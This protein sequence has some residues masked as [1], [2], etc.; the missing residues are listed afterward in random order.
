L[1]VLL[2]LI[3]SAPVESR[4]QDSTGGTISGHIHG[5]GDV[6]V[7]GATVMLVNPQTGERKGTWS[8]A[9]GNYLI[10]NVPPGT[11]KLVVSLVGFRDDVRQ[12]V[13]VTAG[14]ILKVN[15]A[16]E[17]AYGSRPEEAAVANPQAAGNR[18]FNPESLPPQIR[19]RLQSMASAAGG[20]T[21]E[22]V[23]ANV[24]FT[25]TDGAT[26]QLA[27]PGAAQG[28]EALS[29]SPD[30][31]ASAANSFLLSGSVAEAA[32]PGER[33]EMRRRFERFRQMRQ[34]ETAPGFGGEGPGGGR[35][36]GGGG[37][38]P[39][40]M[41]MGGRFGGRRPQVNRIRGSVF[42]S[43]TNSALDAHP[44]PLNVANSP[45]IPSYSERAGVNFGGPLSIPGIYHGKD[46]TSFFFNY[47]LTRSRN[48]FDSLATVPSPANRQGN[49]S[50]L[51]KSGFDASGVCLDRDASGNVIDQLYNPQSD[52][53]GP[54]T[55]FAGNS[56]ASVPLDAAATGLL[57]YIPLPNLPGTVQNFHLQEALPNS[58]DR[59]MGRVGHEISSRDNVGVFYFLNS[60]RSTAVSS[61]PLL[62]H[63][64]STLGQN[65]NVNESHTFNPHLINNLI[66][67]FNRQ[68]TST[69]NP[70]A[71]Q[72][73]IS[74]NLGI[75]GISQDPRDWGLPQVSFT[76]FTGL[77]DT[78]P[79]LVRNQTWRA[80]DM[81]IWSAGKHNLRLG[82]EVRRVQMNN[83]Q[84]PDARGTFTFNGFTTSDLTAA[85]Q[86]VGGTGFDFADFLLG[87]PQV[88]TVR[89]GTSSNYFRS[90]VFSGFIQDDWRA[91]THLTLNLGARYE[92]FQPMT[93]KYGHLSDLAVSPGFA[94]A[95][96]LTAQSP[97][98]LPDS[99]IRPD[100][101]NWAPR[102]GIAYR[103]WIAHRLVMRA[104]YGI[105]YDDSIYQRL[106][107]NLANQPP[108]AEASTLT[109]SPQQVL[110]L[111]NGFPQ[112]NPAIARNTYA[113]DPN[114]RTPY[115]QTWNFSVEDEI[116]TDW[117]LTLG[118]VGTKGTKLDLL[119]G[120][121]LATS[122][123]PLDTQSQ[124]SLKNAQQFTY[125][126]SGAS[127]IYQ[128]LTVELRRQFHRG[129][130]LDALYT[131]SKSLDDAS[132][133]G[134]AG[135]TV[136]Q[137]WQ[138]LAAERGLS[139]FDIRHRLTLRHSFE[140]PF[141]DRKRFLNHGG[142][143]AAVLGD[144]RIMGNATIQ[145]G[146]PFT[147]SALGNLSAGAGM[148]AY[149]SLRADA[150]GQPVGLP[151]SQRTTLEFF[152]TAAFAPPVPGAFGNAG[153][154]TIP[155]PGKVNY[156]LSVGRLLTI[157]R[158]KNIWADI[159]L[160]ANNVFNTP[161]YTG[162]ATVVNATDFGRVT[163]VAA[164]RTLTLTLRLRF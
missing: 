63:S 7:P 66:V 32:M 36:F 77:N 131:F 151:T 84:D 125:E 99:L 64:T 42:E 139:S 85:G 95:E 90:W 18:S 113:V 78:I 119:L 141:G 101:N 47:S 48:P 30:L 144:W 53:F 126:T 35:G 46:K 49:F 107:G 122:G 117:I 71:Y 147:A 128:G 34:S 29:E 16:L 98:A 60:S 11:Y 97:G 109:S 112:V 33:E 102:V 62:T 130:S 127:S 10:S 58:T 154:N 82:G 28:G 45:Q 96:V 13:P 80:M 111:Q 69:L 143:L 3:A 86:P 54:R 25:A 41:L 52:P 129:L 163:S 94:S 145:T 39:V 12:P 89:F 2:G 155:G 38:G 70:F 67:N 51:C 121:N 22:D 19:E 152:N 27:V 162:L 21:G 83:L 50:A 4:A 142:A 59:V 75:Q 114:F 92:Y 31:Q 115:G 44:Y 24:R 74:G 106:V 108:F 88:T 104:G 17:M 9:S 79:S 55:P 118:Y 146:T 26:G 135:H 133:V 37:G 134:G 56:L 1:A 8:D 91:G 158:E 148:G 150:T 149:Q 132:S 161:Q 140:L 93:E 14:K 156:D 110:T 15:V 87:L 153:R 61:F 73:D 120:P 72:Q 20:G 157:S 103:P 65:V 164:M 138:D 43:Y 100:K 137:N 159:R 40:F 116:L 23:S 6:S 57:P 5:P 123:S 105:F 68:R 160:S 76:N 81:V 124:L 136:A